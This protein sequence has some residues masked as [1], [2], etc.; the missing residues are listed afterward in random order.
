MRSLIG[1]FTVSGL[2]FFICVSVAAAGSTEPPKEADY[3]LSDTM[4][5]FWATDTMINESVL[6]VSNGTESPKARLLFPAIK[7][8]S[9]KNAALNK[10][11][12][13]GVDWVYANDTLSLLPG[14]SAPSLTT[15]QMY[16]TEKKKGWTFPKRGGGFVLWQEGHYFHDQQL[17]VTYTHKEGLWNGP[18]PEYAG[19]HLPNTLSKLKAGKPAK[20]V[21]YGDSITK[22]GN[23]S[24]FTGAL[25]G[26]PPIGELFVEYQR[27]VY[28]SSITVENTAVGGKTSTWGVANVHARVT[29]KKPDLVVLAF[30]MNDGTGKIKPDDFLKNIRAMMQDVRK[31]QPQAEFILVAPT[32]ANSESFFAGQQVNYGPKLKT[33]AGIGVQVVDMA[34]VHQELLKRKHFR[35]MTGNNINHSNDFLH[36]WYAQQIAGL[37]VDTQF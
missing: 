28:A 10:T 24:G 11:Y 26:M 33:L 5:P 32:L 2:L 4:I 34:A 15:Q 9:V 12:K 22:G 27:S 30:G 29:L 13:E 3:I 1:K 20:I 7:I 14:S 19:A 36:R 16:P 37:L 31:V 6:M 8:L 17:A 23:A 18:I 35:D 25:P 21:L